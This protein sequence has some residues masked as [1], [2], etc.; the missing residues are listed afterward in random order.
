MMNQIV[1]VGRLTKDIEKIEG[2]RLECIATLAV[3]RSYKNTDG[4]YESDIIPVILWNGIAENATEY[5]R[6][7]DVVGIKGR[8]QS[9]DGKIELVAERVTFLSSS[10]REETKDEK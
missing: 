5:C 2:D 8:I 3:T 10:K 9:R 1:L 6:K 7:G 4:E